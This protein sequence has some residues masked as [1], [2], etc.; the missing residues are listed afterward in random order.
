MGIATF[1]SILELISFDVYDFVIYYES[2]KNIVIYFGVK[3]L[4]I[5]TSLG[6]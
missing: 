3:M 5:H 2:E 4:Q 6:L 1:Y